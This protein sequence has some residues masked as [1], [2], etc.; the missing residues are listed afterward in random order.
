MP[1]VSIIIP[2]YNHGQ[3]LIDRLTTIAKQTYKNWEAIIIDDK[4]SDNSVA[5]ITNFIK[6]NPAF[7]VKHFL[8]NDDNSD[9]GYNSW[10][11]GIE[12]AE[13]EFIWIAET[14]D[15]SDRN[16][17]MELVSILEEHSNCELVFCNS[18]YV[19]NDNIIYTSSKRTADLKIQKDAFGCFDH[20]VLL[21][22]MPFK[23]YITNGSAVV[24]RK[25]INKIPIEIFNN[26][27]CSDLFLWSY[28]VQGSSFAFLNKELNY[29][30]RHAGSI[31]TYLQKFQQESIYHEKAKYLN[32]FTQSQKHIEFID[33]YIKHYIW[34]NK[35]DF[36]NTASIQKIK[37]NK[38]LKTLYFYRLLRFFIFKFLKR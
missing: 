26:R 38:N 22:K 4:S 30:R 6:D 11:K 14:D 18:N 37:A 29:F 13:T 24:F 3:F 21:N 12:L 23:T 7:K 17:L 27:L 9:S 35:K 15:Y 31:S 2:S 5:I 10:Q 33:H 1:K 8:I 32:F 16:F 34:S 20:I 19:E 28:L 36:L 25:P